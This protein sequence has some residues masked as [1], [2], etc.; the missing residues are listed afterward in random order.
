[1][2]DIIRKI[3]KWLNGPIL[4]K[5]YMEDA[6]ISI[7]DLTNREYKDICEKF[8]ILVKYYNI[9][10]FVKK[11]KK[12][13]LV[14]KI[15][16][17]IFS[18]SFPNITENDIKFIINNKDE[19]S[20]RLVIKNE[21]YTPNIYTKKCLDYYFD[22][23]LEYSEYYYNFLKTYIYC[24]CIHKGIYPTKNE[25]SRYLKREISFDEIRDR[26][27]EF[28]E[29]SKSDEDYEKIILNGLL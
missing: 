19:I 23:N 10:S 3:K 8:D 16:V 18:N 17:K 6:S 22:H 13:L 5:Q 4:Y 2:L 9:P 24:E 21:F 11:Y 27:Q 7:E 26:W 1:M 20:N 14:N 12:E 28:E 15:D 25:I 29:S